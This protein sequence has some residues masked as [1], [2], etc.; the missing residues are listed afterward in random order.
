MAHGI[1]K[2]WNENCGLFDGPVEVDE[3]YVGGEE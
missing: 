2:G 3:T 1:R